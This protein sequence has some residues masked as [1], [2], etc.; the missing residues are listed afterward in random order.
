MT[1]KDAE[2]FRRSM[3]DARPLKSGERV[4]EPKQK[5]A[6]KARF[7]RADEE[8][9]LREMVSNHQQLLKSAGMGGMK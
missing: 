9:V 3:S 5:P 6:P 1:D 4:P 8:Q 2:Y 7:S